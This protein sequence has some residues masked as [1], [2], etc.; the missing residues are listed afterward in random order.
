MDI[1]D[2]SSSPFGASFVP[3]LPSENAE[4]RGIEPFTE[5]NALEFEQYLNA[6]TNRSTITSIRR[7]EM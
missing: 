5:A 4:P 3:L 6:S 2:P 1:N 7:Q